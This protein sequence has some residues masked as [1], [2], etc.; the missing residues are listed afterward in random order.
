MDRSVHRPAGAMPRRGRRI[1]VLVSILVGL[2]SGAVADEAGR[3]LTVKEVVGLEAFGRASL[4]PGEDWAVYER[5][6]PYETAARFDLGQRS[7]WTVME[8]WR[9]DLRRPEAPPERLLSDGEFATLCGPWSPS[10][11]RLVV[12][13]LVGDRFEYGV[14]DVGA[15][16]VRWTG[17][18]AEISSTG[19]AVDWAGED[20]VVFIVRPNGSLPW[21]LRYYSGSQVKAGEAWARSAS[22]QEASRTVIDADA[23]VLSAGAPAVV[24]VTVFEIESGRTRLLAEGGI[25][26]IAVSPDGRTAAVVERGES[27]AIRPDAIAPLPIK[28]RHRLRLVDLAAGRVVEAA[29]DLDIAPGLLRWSPQS[30]ELLVWA[31]R[32]GE[33]WDRGDLLRVGKDGSVRTVERGGLEP[34]DPMRGLG[35]LSGVRADWIG[36]DPVLYARS[37]GETRFDWHLLT[38][39]GKAVNLTKDLAAAPGR[40]N[41]IGDGGLFLVADGAVWRTNAEGLVRLTV[42]G[43]TF[44]DATVGDTEQSFRQRMNST[45]RR[46]WATAVTSDGQAASIGADGSVSLLGEATGRR[47]LLAVGA[48]AALGLE[49]RRLVED[50]RLATS[51]GDRALDR[52]NGAVSDISLS[53][54]VEIRHLDR[55]GR[56]TVSRLFPPGGRSWAEAKG[57]I[58]EVYPGT[59][60]TGEWFGPL[61]LTYGLRAQVLAAEGYAVLSPS[62]PDDPE[63]KVRP[64]DLARSVDLAVDAMLAAHPDLPAD[65]MAVVGHS[66]GGYTALAV[67][68]RSKRFRSYVSWAGHSDLFGKW[69][70]FSP[71]T[72]QMPEEGT[73]IDR[74]QA[75]VETGQINRG[76]LPWAAVEA[77]VE[78]S[79]YLAADRIT[80]PV[81]LITA[82]RD[83]STVSQSE[84]M[85]SALYRLGG[86]TR[87]I[88][89]GGEDHFLWSPANIQDLYTQV[90]AWLDLTL[91]SGTTGAPP[92][93]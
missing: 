1:A 6:G 81:L 66:F 17:L 45:S 52:T 13:R 23:G 32:D 76:A 63:R 93:P 77:Y 59:V 55:L 43:Q 28:D 54:P 21:L 90:F 29:R 40:I 75:W 74:N 2:A 70:E 87:L 67:A 25:S 37:S 62:I 51:T 30:G 48:K 64:D 36:D 73:M 9:V 88:T 86:R 78:G 80:A 22:G 19:A 33:P 71:V 61:A 47:R 46:E 7:T 24:A 16:T 5:R 84:R 56:P 92:T 83:F 31:R 65:L 89:Y 82:D 57:V 35:L 20:R 85:F 14:V 60:E 38:P 3:P 50:L 44:V 69:G 49:A 15:R 53:H 11:R 10:G 39:G 12:C 34:V 26:D 41:A 79:P 72:R 4:S 42:A 68:T 27:L 8:L 91:S 58:V 18:A